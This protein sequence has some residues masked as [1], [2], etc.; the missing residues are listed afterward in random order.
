MSIHLIYISGV[1][2]KSI[3]SL[4]NEAKLASDNLKS[5]NVYKLGNHVTSIVNETS[6]INGKEVTIHRVFT[7]TADSGAYETV[8]WVLA[9]DVKHCMICSTAF[10]YFTYQHHCVAC[11]NIVCQKC[12]SNEALVFEI[13]HLGA[14][15][16]CDQCY[17][18]QV[19]VYS[20]RVWWFIDFFHF[21]RW[22]IRCT[23]RICRLATPPRILSAHRSHFMH[24]PFRMNCLQKLRWSPM[25]TVWTRCASC[26]A[27]STRFTPN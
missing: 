16:V 25:S 8:G 24:T 26:T 17:W 14:K 10:G 19:C 11:G 18:G 22:C 9:C 2:N 6:V 13:Q 27:A 20:P 4:Q 1:V 7:H 3:E 5:N 15:R 21:R 23:D 12:S